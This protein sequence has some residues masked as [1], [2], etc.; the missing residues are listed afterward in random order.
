[1]DVDHFVC[2]IGSSTGV[3]KEVN[4]KDETGTIKYGKPAR[5][6]EVIS[7]S[8]GRSKGEIVVAKKDFVAVLNNDYQPVLQ[9]VGWSKEEQIVGCEFV[10]NGL[11][12]M[13]VSGKLYVVTETEGQIDVSSLAYTQVEKP[14][15]R[16]AVSKNK[17][18]LIAFGGKENRLRV[19]DTVTKKKV[20]EARNP[21]DDWLCLR[22]PVWISGVAFDN[23]NGN[24][25]HIAAVSRYHE[26]QLYDVKKEDRRPL[27]EVKIGEDPL[28]CVTVSNSGRIVC[29]S[30]SGFIYIVNG[31]TFQ[32]LGRTTPSCFGSVRDVVV[33][34]ELIFAVGLDRFIY[35]CRLENK[36]AVLK[37]V[38]AK[39]KM[40]RVLVVKK[41][42]EKKDEN[43]EE[44]DEDE[45]D[46]WNRFK[47][48]EEEEKKEK[49]TKNSTSKREE[50]EEEKEDPKDT[51]AKSLDK[52]KRKKMKK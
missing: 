33:E 17:T 8:F 3:V 5:D 49:R 25:D 50:R 7:L 28:N 45:D 32:V 51:V 19:W 37:K 52:L 34:D 9:I 11:M 48:Q 20:F 6:N 31:E 39:Q 15:D 35:C 47:R 16:V 10:E 2:I 26:L 24:V 30:S 36:R 44:D 1:M 14:V 23:N 27:R 21:P 38:Y 29:G 13:T 42:I 12:V 41:E 43:E 46:A 22:T 4:L 18:R 40:N